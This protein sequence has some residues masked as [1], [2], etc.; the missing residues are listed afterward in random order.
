MSSV[1]NPGTNYLGGNPLGAKVRALEV[2]V[3]TLRK[4]VAALT[5]GGSSAATGSAGPMGPAGPPGPAGP[6]GPAGATGPAGPAGPAGPTGPMTYIA[7]PQGMG[8]MMSPVT[9]AAPMPVT[10]AMPAPVPM[11]V[12][13]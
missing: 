4:Q 7:M 6:A 8:P 9:A 12:S 5:A 10:A 1:T 13:V 11:P 2:L 3:E